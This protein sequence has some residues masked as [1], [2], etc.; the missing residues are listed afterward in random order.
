VT[1]LAWAESL[2]SLS[3]YQV[4]RVAPTADSKAIKSAF[5]E[6]A[7]RCHPD[8]Y[9]DDTE[10]VADAAATVFKRAVEAYGILSKPVLR[11]RYDSMLSAGTLRMNPDD[12]VPEKPKAQ[13]KTFEMFAISEGAKKHARKADR[14]VAIGEL[15]AA[16]LA[17][18]DA[19][20][21]DFGNDALK[22]CL[23]KV[24]EAIAA[25]K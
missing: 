1:F 9:V 4:L 23:R 21:E 8:Q 11:G 17:L 3:Y 15:E 6:L 2:E 20:R 19:N 16:R 5:H 10:D 14:L 7:K 13:K 24:Y 25:K 12:T 22:H 18:V